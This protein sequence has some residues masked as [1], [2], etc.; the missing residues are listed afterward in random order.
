MTLSTE[1]HIDY[2]TLIRN[3]HIGFKVVPILEDGKTPSMKWGEIYSDS[4]FWNEKKLHDTAHTFKNIAT[5]FGKTHLRDQDGRELYLNMIDIDSQEVFNRLAV[6]S[7]KDK[8]HFFIGDMRTQTYVVKT[9]KKYG[10]HM[11]WMS[12]TLNSP[13]ATLRC[14][15]NHEFEIKTD[16]SGGLGTLP[17]SIHRDDPTFHYRSV[18]Q[19]SI[20]VNDRMYEGLLKVLNDCV[21]KDKSQN[22]NSDSHQERKNTENDLT[23][24]ECKAI[25]TVLEPYYRKGHRHMM[26]FGLSGFLR[27]NRISSNS[28]MSIVISI[29]AMDEESKSRVRIVED[30]YKKEPSEVSGTS[31][32][33]SVIKNSTNSDA[34]SKSVFKVISDIVMNY[35]TESFTGNNSTELLADAI[36]NDHVFKTMKDTGEIYC[37]DPENGI[38]KSDGKI[39]IEILCEVLKA[40]IKTQTVTEVVNKIKRRTYVDRIEFDANQDVQVLKN[41]VLNIKTLELSP[42]SQSFLSTVQLPLKYDPKAKCL[43]IQK[44]LGQ[45]F[46][47]KDV[48]TV[49]QF[50]GYILIKNCKYEKALLLYGDGKNG[51]SVFIK[52]IESFVG[53][54]NTSHVSYLELESD[55]F[56]SA[57][58]YR[59]YVNVLADLKPHKIRSTATLKKIVSADSTRAQRKYGQPFDFINFAKLIFSTNHV[60][61]QDDDSYAFYRRWLFM[62]CNNDVAPEDY[63]PNLISKLTTDEEL[64]GLLNLVLI[65]LNYL[66]SNDGFDDSAFIYQDNIQKTSSTVTTFLGERCSFESLKYTG[67]TELHDYYIKFCQGRK[68]I[69]LNKEAFGKEMV[70]NGIIRK[71]L[72]RNGIKSY[73]YMG[74][75]IRQNNQ[76]ELFV[77]K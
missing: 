48:F 2:R 3:H 73:Y 76:Q 40:D 30:T 46:E 57:D 31:L 50:I 63:D 20:V 58:L 43:R 66:E 4:N 18:G 65:G 61:E 72:R 37:Y 10:Y 15:Q 39:K 7:I 27:K 69:P 70:K 5:T 53:M 77:T 74:I 62:N 75:A 38:Y 14:K 60:P 49:L 12:H 1:D 13:I 44:F 21:R 67:T 11:Y 64:S 8:D 9:K 51:K 33:M 35:N 34:E 45:T 24:D 6:V 52:I 41:G 71:Q 25:V 32:F 36:M 42:H 29:S 26:C 28:S 19:N 17:P 47:P 55:K 54:Q 16:K 22:F 59:K 23:D 68:E 56:A